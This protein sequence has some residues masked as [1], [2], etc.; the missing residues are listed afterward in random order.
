MNRPRVSEVPSVPAYDPPGPSSART[1]TAHD[2]PFPSRGPEDSGQKPIKRRKLG[3]RI[4]GYTAA[5]LGTTV[6]F[7]LA[8]V[9]SVVMHVGLP[10]VRRVASATVTDILASSFQGRIVIEG[11][12]TLRLNRVEGLRAALYEPAADGGEEVAHIAGGHAK[13]GLYQL[14]ASLISSKGPLVIPVKELT[15]DHAEVKLVTRTDGSLT[16]AHAFD[17]KETT[18]PAKPAGQSKGTDLEF[19][20]VLLKH[21]WIHGAMAGQIIDADLASLGAAASIKPDKI[22]ADLKSLNVVARA[23]VPLPI[24]VDAKGN[25]SMPVYSDAELKADPNKKAPITAGADVNVAAGAV[26]AVIHGT[27]DDDKIAATVDVPKTQP[28]AITALVPTAPV[29]QEVDAHVDV[30]GT[31]EHL[32]AVVHADAGKGAVDINGSADIGKQ[33]RADADIALAHIDIS[34][35]SKGT[36]SDLNTHAKVEATVDGGQ[37]AGTFD[38]DN[39]PGSVVGQAVPAAKLGAASPRARSTRAG[40]SSSRVLPP[41]SR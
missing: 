5:A 19:P 2:P 21:A 9:G 20:S 32:V 3:W 33:I 40:T 12:D 36:P 18:T 35:F 7:A 31:M 27:M 4:A 38:V 39:A 14:L 16:I 10:A 25:F 30:K 28:G 37:V 11:I 1:H 41:R 29:Y 6:T 23:V 13:V 22:N 17:P 34:A 15:I 24:V 26:K 8:T